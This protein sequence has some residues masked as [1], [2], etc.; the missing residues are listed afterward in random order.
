MFNF[1]HLPQVCMNY[2]QHFLFSFRLSCLFLE[3]SAKAL[4]HAVIPDFYI[5]SS[6]ETVKKIDHLIKTSGCR[7]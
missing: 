5:T 2:K 1:Q 3:A 7:A 4:I 6:S